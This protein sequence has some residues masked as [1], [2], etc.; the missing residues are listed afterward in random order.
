MKKFVDRA[1]LVACLTKDELEKVQAR[2]SLRGYLIPAW[3]VMQVFGN[4]SIKEILRIPADQ[5]CL[6]SHGTRIEGELRKYK[7]LDAAADP[8]ACGID[9]YHA[10]DWMCHNNPGKIN[11]SYTGPSRGGVGTAR[12]RVKAGER[13]SD[14]ADED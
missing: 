13:P 14:F 11:F 3:N 8:E 12:S 9:W 5:E 1:L 7:Y 6:S 4:R 10:F 2:E